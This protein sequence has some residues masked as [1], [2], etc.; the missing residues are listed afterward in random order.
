MSRRACAPKMRASAR[1]LFHSVFR[2]GTIC[3]LAAGPALATMCCT[4]ARGGP[5]GRPLVTDGPFLVYAEAGAVPAQIARAVALSRR[6][7]VLLQK[8]VLAPLGPPTAARPIELRLFRDARS[9][10]LF[11]GRVSPLQAVAHFSR[12]DMGVYVAADATEGALRHELA[13]AIVETQR[14]R[15]PYWIHEGLAGF[16]QF[17]R[18][19]ASCHTPETAVLPPEFLLLLREHIQAIRDP[20]TP[21]SGGYVIPEGLSCS[22]RGKRNEDDPLLAAYLILY[23]HQR[24]NYARFLSGWRPG[25]DPEFA[26]LEVER[27]PGAD[28]APTCAAFAQGFLK[29]LGSRAPREGGRGC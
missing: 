19:R 6:N 1:T 3:V 22:L 9:Y 5:F 2:V 14:P 27:R 21:S 11:V 29:W 10:G 7:F 26:L 28:N 12:T 17:N 25:Q 24:R 23:V 18:V 13:H 20:E 16:A 8:D 4:G 15:A